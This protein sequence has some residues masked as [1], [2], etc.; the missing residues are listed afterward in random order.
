MQGST[1]ELQHTLEAKQRELMPLSKRVCD[2]ESALAV[3]KEELDLLL[4]Q[5]R[6]Q[7]QQLEESQRS[8]AKASRVMLSCLYCLLR[9]QWVWS[10]D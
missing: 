2:A 9:V 5:A 1:A 6:K 10:C 7:Q 3:A 4:S 8:L